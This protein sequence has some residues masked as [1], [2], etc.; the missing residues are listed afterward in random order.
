[1]NIVSFD[2][3][4][5]LFCFQFTNRDCNGLVTFSKYRMEYDRFINVHSGDPTAA[6]ELEFYF[7][8]Y[9]DR[10]VLFNEIDVYGCRIQLA[11]MHL[12]PFLD[13]H[14]QERDTRIEQVKDI[15]QKVGCHW[16]FAILAGTLNDIPLQ[17]RLK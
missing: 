4:S 17:S 16:N 10:A 1:M 5:E 12:S 11:N 9:L 6:E 8:R 7:D 15:L 3:L 13:A 14:E 2:L